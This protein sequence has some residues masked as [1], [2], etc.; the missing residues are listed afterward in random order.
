MTTR[1]LGSGLILEVADVLY[2]GHRL[3]VEIQPADP[4]G[5]INYSAFIRPWNDDGSF[6]DKELAHTGAEN[7]HRGASD[8]GFDAARGA[9]AR[10]I[11]I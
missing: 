7:S 1:H 11:R 5:Q 8:A 4:S 2:L 10:K 9:V 3:G 6:A